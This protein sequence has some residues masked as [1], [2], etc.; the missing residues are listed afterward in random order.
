M[1]T[2]TTLKAINNLANRLA[3]H[4]GCG[5]YGALAD[6]KERVKHNGVAECSRWIAIRESGKAIAWNTIA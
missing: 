6:V 4:Q 5:F 2:K 3:V 1:T